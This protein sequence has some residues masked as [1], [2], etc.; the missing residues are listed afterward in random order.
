MT[1]QVYTEMSVVFEDVRFHRATN[2]R[3]EGMYT[4]T[5]LTILPTNGYMHISCLKMIVFR[6]ITLSAK[7]G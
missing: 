2:I 7:D 5:L 4:N 3:K 1:D 6:L